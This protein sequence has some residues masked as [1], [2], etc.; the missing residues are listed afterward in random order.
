MAGAPGKLATGHDGCESGEA[1][2]NIWIPKKA[3]LAP[4]SALA[5]KGADEQPEQQLINIMYY[6]VWFGSVCV[7][8][9][10]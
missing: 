5:G 9:H 7:P 2:P 4:I 1:A 6:V 10:E 3:T 8:V